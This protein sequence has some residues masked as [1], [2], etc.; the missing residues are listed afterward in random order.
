M[1][2]NG[3]GPA[4]G[5][6]RAGVPIRI[7]GVTKRYLSARGGEVPALDEIDL[8]IAGGAFVSIIGP[9]GCD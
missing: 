5:D 4:A 8:A 7:A 9:N 1:I 3:T 6:F 2:D